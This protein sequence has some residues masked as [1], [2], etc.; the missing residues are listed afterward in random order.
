MCCWWRRRL[1][2]RGRFYATGAA[3]SACLSRRCAC[4]C[5]SRTPSARAMLVRTRSAS[6][7]DSSG[8]K[9]TP[10]GNRSIS[11]A[12]TAKARRVLPTPPLGATAGSRL[13]RPPMCA[14]R[15]GRAVGEAV[16]GVRLLAVAARGG[17]VE[18]AVRW[19]RPFGRARNGRN[20]LAHLGGWRGPRP[21]SPPSA[22]KGAVHRLRPCE[23][24]RQRILPVGPTAL[25]STLDG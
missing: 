17:P 19:L 25:G 10:S 18:G 5:A 3:A 12:V 16:A 4:P 15:G 7:I 6:S 14:R 24:S 2:P 1:P 23:W 21:I 13:W 8:A 20:A 9:E 22:G 11:W